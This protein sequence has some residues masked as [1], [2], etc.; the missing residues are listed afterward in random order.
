MNTLA[1]FGELD[2]PEAAGLAPD[3]ILSRLRCG[4]DGLSSDD[5]AARLRQFG[6]N[7]LSTHQVRPSVVLWRQLRNPILLLLLA[8]AL[9]SGRCRPR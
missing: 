1:S 8:A 5:A 9:V 6:P 4:P 2:L 3:E 7:A